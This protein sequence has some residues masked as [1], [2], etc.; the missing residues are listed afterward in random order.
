MEMTG[1]SVASQQE[2]ELTVLQDVN[3]RVMSGDYWVVAGM[4]ASGKSDLIAVAGGLTRP[5]AGEYRLFG[6]LMPL[7]EDEKLPERLR[8]GVVFDASHL[9]HR[10]TVAENV[11][12]PLRYHRELGDHEIAERVTAILELTEL[13]NTAGAMPGRLGRNWQKRAMLARALALEPEVLLLDNPLGGLDSRHAAWWLNFLGRLS[14]GEGV[15]KGRRLTLLATAEDLR[16]WK[17]RASHFAILQ[18][19]R[20]VTLGQ[21]S[22]LAGHSEPLVKEMLADAYL[23]GP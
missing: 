1:L 23:A 11:A 7:Y 3:L 10:L 18:Q 2:P 12:L 15:L 5:L 21:R 19:G 14:T 9:L 4:H 13:T 8:I 20:L 6:H 17:D 16:P 22:L